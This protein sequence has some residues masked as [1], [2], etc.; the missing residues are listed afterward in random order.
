SFYEYLF[1]NIIFVGPGLLLLVFSLNFITLS[2]SY[3]ETYV[4]T[5]KDLNDDGMLVGLEDEIYQD[6]PYLRTF[7]E[8]EDIHRTYS[9]K[10]I[11]L[12]FANGLLGIRIIKSRRLK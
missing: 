9:A 4:I 11:E 7:S 1:Y 6:K 5:T 12:E 2:P 3:T 10:K 8:Y